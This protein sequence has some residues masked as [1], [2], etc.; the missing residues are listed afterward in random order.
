MKVLVQGWLNLPHSYCIVNVYQILALLKIP[1]VEI[2]MDNID[3]YR[4]NWETIDLN[5]LVSPT[6]KSILENLKEYDKDI[7][8]DIIY[9]ISFPLNISIGLLSPC[10]SIV[11][12]YTCEFG[13]IEDGNFCNGSKSSSFLDFLDKCK[14]RQ[15]LPI[16]PSNWSSLPLKKENYEPLVISHGVD[17]TKYYPIKDSNY[18]SEIRKR[19]NISKDSFVFLN[20]GAATGNKNI[21]GIIKAFYNT[22]HLKDTILVLKGLEDLYNSESLIMGYIKELIN[23]KEIDKQVWKKI[24]SRIIYIPDTFSYKEMNELYN[25]SNCYISPYIAEGFNLPVLES[26]ACGKPV[27]I[28]KGGPTDDFTNESVAKYIN[29]T[30][31]KTFSGQHLFIAN[32]LS[33]QEEMINVIN[34]LEFQK[35]A[36]DYGPKFVKN[37][38]TWD[39]IA[40]QLVNFFDYI[41]H[42]K[43]SLTTFKKTHF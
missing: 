2:H 16:T 34:D 5:L 27:I 22:L 18:L 6:E 7:E 19:Y 32:E 25:M 41:I 14:N 15:I 35:Q 10:T 31:V 26:I 12:F 23:S 30:A 36:S 3:K 40:Q 13:F 33:I 21:K 29:T 1:N 17:V 28:T 43:N 38:Y 8:Y 9:R 39:I 37:K 20:I 24:K 4:E 11:L 42:E